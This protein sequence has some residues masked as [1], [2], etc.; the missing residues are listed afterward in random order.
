MHDESNNG[1][2]II[3]YLRSTLKR[4]TINNDMIDESG[5]NLKHMLDHY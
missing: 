1:K 5:P 4:L 3:V 2:K